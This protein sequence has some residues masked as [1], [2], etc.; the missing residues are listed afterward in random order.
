MNYYCSADKAA[1]IPTSYYHSSTIPPFTLQIWTLFLAPQRIRLLK[2]RVTY[3]LSPASFRESWKEEQKNK[4]LLI[5]LKSKARIP[6]LKMLNLSGT[7]LGARSYS[8]FVLL[9]EPM[10]VWAPWRLFLVLSLSSALPFFSFYR[11]LQHLYILLHLLLRKMKWTLWTMQTNKTLD[12]LQTIE[13]DVRANKLQR[14]QLIFS[15]C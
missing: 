8:R 4:K 10:S 1:I 7:L 14:K 2:H 13:K 3:A 9:N 11:F 5:L 12:K 6:L 15:K